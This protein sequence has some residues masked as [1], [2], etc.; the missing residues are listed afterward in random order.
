MD[1]SVFEIRQYQSYQSCLKLGIREEN[2]LR[3]QY[4]CKITS[5]IKHWLEYIYQDSIVNSNSNDAVLL[6]GCS[7]MQGE[8]IEFQESFSYHLSKLLDINTYNRALGGRG[9]SEMYFQTQILY[10]LST[11]EKMKNNCSNDECSEQDVINKAIKSLSFDKKTEKYFM[12][13]FNDKEA[14]DFIYKNFSPIIDKN[15]EYIFYIYIDDHIRRYYTRR[16]PDTFYVDRLSFKYDKKNNQFILRNPY[17]SP[18][19][20]LYIFEVLREKFIKKNYLDSPKYYE[21]N[22][23]MWSQLMLK[24]K[25]IFDKIY[26][27]RIKKYV[28][29]NYNNMLENKYSYNLM[30][31]LPEDSFIVV[32][33]SDLVDD[34]INLKKYVT[35]WDNYHPSRFVWE[36]ATP[37]I[38]KIIKENQE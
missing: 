11:I 3:N 5:F 36:E 24:T 15:I 33:I 14:K 23:Y 17:F 29:I 31:Y 25:E 8:G 30:K 2:I 13:I 37:K 20:T 9:I 4:F 18:Y 26:N 21:E 34:D 1:Y 27:N 22:L 6:L 35:P 28:I 38:V 16:E 7:F 10:I 19:R 32:N 12:E